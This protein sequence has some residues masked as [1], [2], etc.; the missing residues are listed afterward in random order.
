MTPR[1]VVC[2]LDGT[3]IEGSS[4][5][6][7]LLL[8]LRG[9]VMSAGGLL[10]FLMAY[11]AHPVRT[12][13]EGKAWNRRYLKGVPLEAVNSAAVSLAGRL[14]RSIRPHVAARLRD[15]RT[16]G[17]RLALLSASLEP[18]V[19]EIAIANGFDMFRGSSP[20]VTGGVCTGRVTGIRPWGV[21]KVAAAREMILAAGSTPGETLALGDS[22]SDR[23]L[24][25]MCARAVAV[26]PDTRLRAL[27][28]K[29]GWMVLE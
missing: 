10:A 13:R 2:D 19:R 27:S 8:L 22:Y 28:Q 7:F 21:A 12:V 14:E 25:E 1:L 23:H 29:R 6:E 18:L 3:L 4:E 5:R 20:E 15:Y 17:A 16:S 9:G 24:F 11:P 26:H